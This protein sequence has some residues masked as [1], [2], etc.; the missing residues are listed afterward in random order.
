MPAID[1]VRPLV[2]FAGEDVDEEQHDDRRRED[3]L[4]R[5]GMPVEGRVR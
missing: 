1:D 5:E 3:D 2:R 4:G